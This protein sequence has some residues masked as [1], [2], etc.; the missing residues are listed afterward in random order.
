MDYIR[1]L[2]IGGIASIILFS[3]LGLKTL[4]FIGILMLGISIVSSQ[5]EEI[6]RLKR[7]NK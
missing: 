5:L 3:L 1:I 2:G 7:I 4:I 6:N